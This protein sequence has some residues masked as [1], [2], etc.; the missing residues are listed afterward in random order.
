MS[1]LDR[2]RINRRNV[3][4]NRRARRPFVFVSRRVAR[5]VPRHPFSSVSNKQFAIVDVLLSTGSA[6][7]TFAW[8]RGD[9]SLSARSTIDRS[10][11]QQRSPR[12]SS[13]NASTGNHSFVLIQH[14]GNHVSFV[15]AR[16]DNER[17]DRNSIRIRHDH[18]T[19]K[20]R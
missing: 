19:R 13:N 7:R 1:T 20:Q 16:H 12:N 15:A 3:R 6:A 8:Q 11:E 9:T 14:Q 5:N 17:L 10:G 18:W 4:V 2:R